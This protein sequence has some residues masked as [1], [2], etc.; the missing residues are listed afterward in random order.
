MLADAPLLVLTGSGGG[1]GVS[2]EYGLAP[3]ARSF[4]LFFKVLEHFA[5]M[6][7][8]S[9][10]SFPFLSGVAAISGGEWFRMN[11]TW[12]V[13]ELKLAQAMCNGAWFCLSH[14]IRE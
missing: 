11:K 6:V 12:S 14:A 4:K 2:G 10:G 3:S 13:S 7:A 1:R 9:M 5:F 8:R